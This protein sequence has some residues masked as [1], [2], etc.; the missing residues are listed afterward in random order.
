VEP[1]E[2]LEGVARR[3]AQ[4]EAGCAVREL[5]HVLDYY[6]SAGGSSEIISIFHATTDLS[7]VVDGSLFGLAHEHEDIRVHKVSRQQALQWVREG[8]IRA[9]MAIIALQWLA[10]ERGAQP[11]SQ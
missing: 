6:P 1:G 3:E 7:A 9:S 4:E 2:T 8:K 5:Q 10:L 11:L